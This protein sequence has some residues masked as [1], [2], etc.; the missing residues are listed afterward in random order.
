MALFQASGGGVRPAQTRTGCTACTLSNTWSKLA[1]P[2]IVPDTR[3]VGGDNLVDIYFL[4]GAPGS[5]DDAQGI[6]FVSDGG[7]M[8]RNAMRNWPTDINYIFSNVCRCHPPESR[9]P[10]AKEMDACWGAY[11][12]PDFL[13]YKPF[14]VVPFGGEALS[15]FFPGGIA[16]WN[17][18]RVPH[19]Q[20]G[21]SFWV[22]PLYHPS[23]LMNQKKRDYGESD[24]HKI[25]RRSL[26]ALWRGVTEWENPKVVSHAEAVEGIQVFLPNQLQELRQLILAQPKGLRAVDLETNGLMPWGNEAR[27]LSASVSFGSLTVAWL[28]D[29]PENPYVE[30]SL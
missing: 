28:I 9:S 3:G 17:G 15:R 18:V 5:Q 29:H 8:L 22:C 12:Q 16:E 20:D 6:P 2:K 13:S 24:A 7:Q 19:A 11:G 10:S 26:D 1:H 23:Y 27:I 25:W 21:H 30:E 14:V 4:G